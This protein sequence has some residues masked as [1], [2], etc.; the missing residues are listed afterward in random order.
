[1][2]FICSSVSVSLSIPMAIHSWRI[3]P[4][5]ASGM[6][7]RSGLTANPFFMLQQTALRTEGEG[8]IIER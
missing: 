8:A 3:L 6:L 2:R 1:M 4:K 5:Y 7:V